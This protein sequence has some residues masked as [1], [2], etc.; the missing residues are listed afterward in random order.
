M[1]Y[2]KILIM[3]VAGLMSI[4]YVWSADMTNRVIFLNGPS[5]CGKS[6]LTHH[7]Q[8]ALDKPYLHIGIDS[9]IMMMPYKS[10]D[11]K[12]ESLHVE[13]FGW[14]F[15]QTHAGEPLAHLT[16]GPLGNRIQTLFKSLVKTM[17]EEGHHVIIDEVCLFEGSFDQWQALLA[18]YPTLYVGMY[19]SDDE[20]A[21]R[22][23]A[24]G[25][26]VIGSSRA[27]N[28]IVHQG[29]Q[30]DLEL[31]MDRLSPQ[32]CTDQILSRLQF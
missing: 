21:K 5:S 4:G 22:E 8:E 19:V 30:Y 11:W 26:R 14:K 9:V 29:C 1:T 20:L 6:T 12:G 23:L 32:E 31:D 7:L 15:A 27:Q 24:R 13:G 28:L 17:L 10:N 18:D 3:M 25:D 16:A 2:S